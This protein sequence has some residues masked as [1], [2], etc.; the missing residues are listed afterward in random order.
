MKK[1]SD[2]MAILICILLG[3]ISGIGVTLIIYNIHLDKMPRFSETCLDETEKKYNVMM[4][5]VGYDFEIATDYH[6]NQIRC[7]V[8]YEV[9][10]R[11]KQDL[12][13]K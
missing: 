6:T 1:I 7:N 8:K 9:M 4:N 2:E 10:K 13:K 12:D 5:S 3:F 11:I